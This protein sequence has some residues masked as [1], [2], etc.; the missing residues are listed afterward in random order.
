[1]V[2]VIVGVTVVPVTVKASAEVL[3]AYT[4]SPA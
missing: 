4:E 3:A 2:N 1:M